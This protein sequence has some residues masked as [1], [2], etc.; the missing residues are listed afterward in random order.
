VI[1]LCFNCS[2]P[3]QAQKSLAVTTFGQQC[4]YGE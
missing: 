2:E 1:W 4:Y 3:E